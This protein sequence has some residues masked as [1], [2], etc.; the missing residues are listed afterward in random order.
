MGL[1][2][3]LI[4][5]HSR[6][7]RSEPREEDMATQMGRPPTRT[8]ANGSL[9]GPRCSITRPEVDGLTEKRQGD[10]GPPDHFETDLPGPTGRL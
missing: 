2:A 4:T 8:G 7:R 3:T 10:P 9:K 6:T 1:Q 5:T